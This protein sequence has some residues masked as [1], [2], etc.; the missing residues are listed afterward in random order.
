MKSE[1]E[2]DQIER[3]V[4]HVADEIARAD[5]TVVFGNHFE[6]GDI[7]DLVRCDD[8][9]PEAEK[10]VDAFRSGQVARIFSEHIERG[11]IHGG[12]VAED[13]VANFVRFQE[14]AFLPDDDAE[15]AFGIHIVGNVGRRQDDVATGRKHAGRGL[16]EAAGFFGLDSLNIFG[17]PMIIEADAPDFRRHVVGQQRRDLVERNRFD[18]AQVA[19]RCMRSGLNHAQQI[20]GDGRDAAVGQDPGTDLV[21]VAEA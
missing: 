16:H 3:R 20:P 10:R 5:L 7:V 2:A 12:G 11:Q 6:L 15:F 17:V 4:L 8:H 9:G 13:R 14:P 1:W 21:V 19:D 18:A